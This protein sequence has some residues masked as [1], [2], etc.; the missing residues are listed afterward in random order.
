MP[1]GPWLPAQL[2]EKIAQS[3]VRA[4]GIAFVTTWRS[5]C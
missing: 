3:F 2:M 4:L 5:P 1:T